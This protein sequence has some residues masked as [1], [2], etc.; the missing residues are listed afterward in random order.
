MAT[1]AILIATTQFIPQVLQENFGYTATWAG[2]ALSPGG[3]VTMM[4]MFVCGRL[5]T[6]VQPKYLIAI[7]GAII[8][9]AMWDMTR[10]YADLNFGFFVWS[11]VYLGLGLPLIFI[12]ITSASYDGLR[13]DQTD[14]AS[15]LINAARN[16]GGSIGVSVAS[17]VLAH[18]EQWHQSR[19][20]ENVVP[21]AP[22]YTSTLQSMSQYFSERGSNLVDAKSQALAWIGSQVQSQASY[23][24]YIDVFHTLMVISLGVVP[25]ALILRKIDLNKSGGAGAA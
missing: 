16:T 18:R 12:P 21:S 14:Q 15:A 23:L 2:L 13:P 11:R 8:A 17:N 4:M 9:V 24:A 3:V 25:L 19:L 1:G 22:G 20:V 7:G 6:K 5:S 10:L